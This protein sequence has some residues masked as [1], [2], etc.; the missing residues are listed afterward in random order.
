MRAILACLLLCA[1]SVVWGHDFYTGAKNRLG[2]SC[3]GLNDC[4]PIENSEV[5]LVREG[6]A[7][8]F[9]DGEVV[10]PD[11]DTLH[12]PDGRFHKCVWGGQVKCLFVP[13]LGA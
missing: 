7:V 1:S 8:K 12:S 13:P 6:Y 2:E 10:I 3:C 4:A 9:G 11:R 5:R